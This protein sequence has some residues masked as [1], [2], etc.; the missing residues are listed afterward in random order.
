MIRW[1]DYIA[2]FMMADLLV[3]VSFTIPYIGFIVAVAF[4]EF[5]WDTYCLFRKAQEENQ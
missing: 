3:T 1:Y 4:Y 2:A 5:I